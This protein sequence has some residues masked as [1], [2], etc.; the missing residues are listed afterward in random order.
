MHPILADKQKLLLYVALWLIAGVLLGLLMGDSGSAPWG[1][2]LA[3]TIPMTLVYS[4]MSLSS[5][6]LC[7]AFPLQSTSFSRIA[8][9]FLIT[10]AI[11]SSLWLLLGKG[12]VF[13]LSETLQFRGIEELFSVQKRLVFSI[14][15]FLF[16]LAGTVHYL[17]AAFEISREAE[18]RTLELRVLAQDA[19]LRA[20]RAQINPHFLFNSLNS[21]SAL[22]TQNPAA[23][24]TMCNMLAEFLRDSLRLGV[25]EF[26]TLEEEISLASYYLS[27]EQVRFGS[28]LRLKKEIDPN[29]LG[30]P[31]PPLLLQ[32]LCENAVNHG[33]A[34]LLEGGEIRIRAERN[35]ANLHLSIVNPVDPGKPN[36]SGNRLGLENVR[37][38]LRR[39]FEND[40]RLEIVQTDTSFRVDL[41]LPVS[42]QPSRV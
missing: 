15:M 1:Q 33:I 25:K 40:A 18:R 4:F 29:T 31:I 30:V 24:R 36:R 17:L 2:A 5:W 12:I 8:V 23:A 13:V 35:G 6:Y 39:M 3:F 37:K 10:S 16:L 19:E 41:S 42:R 22:T 14:G 9:L 20:L 11:S 21:V 38:R 28:R 7:R 34:H 32:P 27:I 26:V